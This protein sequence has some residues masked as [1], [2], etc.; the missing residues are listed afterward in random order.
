MIRRCVH[1]CFV[2]RA[3]PMHNQVSLNTPVLPR[4]MY[5]QRVVTGIIILV[6]VLLIGIIVW[7]KL[8]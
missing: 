7:E 2:G 6:L 1:S 5:Q 3:W 8:R 4:R